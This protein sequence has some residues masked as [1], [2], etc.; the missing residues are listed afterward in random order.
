MTTL[1]T[2][3]PELL[4]GPW[5]SDDPD[6]V[7]DVNEPATGAVLARVHGARPTQVDAAVRRA[8]GAFATWRHMPPRERG[9]LLRRAG[10]LIAEHHDELARLE[11]REVGKPLEISRDYDMNV[12]INSFEFF[13]GYADKI[14]GEMFGGGPVSTFTTPE[15]Y[16]VVGGIIPFNWPPVHTAA[17]TA[18]A[19]AAGNTIVLKPPPQCPL[20]IMRIVELLQQVFPPGVVEVVPGAGPDV[21]AA[22]VGHPLLGRLSFTGSTAT[23]RAVLKTAA[24]NITGALLELGGKNPFVVFDDADLDVVLPSA[25]EG[26]FFNQ[27]EACTQASR[28]LVHES[29]L[30]EFTDRFVRATSRLI[31]GD[32]LD[33]RTHIGPL[34][35]REQQR[36]VEGYIQLGEDE[37]ARVAHRGEPPSDERLRGGYFVAPVVF[38]DVAAHMR[39]AREEI[40]GPVVTI[41][42]FSSYAEAIEIANATDYGLVAGVFTGDMTLAQRAAR[43]IDAGVVF[44]NNYN[45][46]F[47]GTPF[48]GNRLSGYGREHA[49]ETVREFLR[50]K[51]VRMPSGLGEI[52]M[53]SGAERALQNPS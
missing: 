16:G 11:T 44:V 38:A 1:K 41:H 5:S 42:R 45:R 4:R 19:L 27:G 29:R 48:G 17:K 52:P 46:A 6:D 31:V 34:V 22:L 21:G 23:G 28:M 35:T 33:R 39:I 25:I 24:E 12:C 40:F 18:P 3:S 36:V 51:S 14:H 10:E 8:H 7:F 53:W 43:D 9:R 32:G 15:P 47:L 2:T 13:G 49:V 30:D 50:S 20:T 37:G 26:A